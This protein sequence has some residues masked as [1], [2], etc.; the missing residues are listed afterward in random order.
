[1]QNSSHDPGQAP[2][3]GAA[4]R[5]AGVGIVLGIVFLLAQLLDFGSG[6]DQAIFALVA[7]AIQDGGAP[8]RDA[9]DFKTPGIYAVY[10]L[11]GTLF[12]PFLDNGEMAIRIL[13]VGAILLSLLAFLILSRRFAGSLAAGLI[14]SLVATLG[15][16]ELGYWHTGQPES[17]AVPLLAWAIV[18][19]TGKP[20]PEGSEFP[21]H[22]LAG[23]LYTAAALL[24]PPL[25][26][27]FLVSLVAVYLTRRRLLAPLFAF[28]LGALSILATTLIWFASKGALDALVDTL[29]R[30]TPNYTSLSIGLAELP[31]AL[32]RATRTW[33]LGL[34]PF[35]A[36]GLVLLAILP[37]LTEN[38]RKASLHILGVIAFSLVGVALQG[39]FFEYH[40]GA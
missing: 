20:R 22:L 4:Q 26:G 30:W 6:R 5:A 12:G 28:S 35:H 19:S 1:M 23:A 31:S 29:F 18:F 7:D 24:K 27:G 13:E 36:P 16:V 3:A 38:E 33:L 17:F 37:A 39:K 9:W 32:L 21:A 15:W 10:H 34:S 8:Y 2:S 11:A 40:F 14:G 25:G